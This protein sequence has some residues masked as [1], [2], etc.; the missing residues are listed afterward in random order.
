MST[1]SSRGGLVFI[2][3]TRSWLPSLTSIVVF[4]AFGDPE[5]DIDDEIT[6]TDGP[7]D[8]PVL[9]EDGSWSHE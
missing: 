8:G 4:D 2:T 1:V 3:E 7:D 5:E 6:I 9:T